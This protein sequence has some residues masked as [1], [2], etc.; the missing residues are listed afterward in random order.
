MTTTTRFDLSITIGNDAM[1]T[2]TDVANA[3]R[4][5]VRRLDNMEGGGWY[6]TTGPIRDYNGNR[7]GEWLIDAYS[8]EEN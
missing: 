5:V 1:Q 8:T 3:L 4:R 2:P 6:D 7:V